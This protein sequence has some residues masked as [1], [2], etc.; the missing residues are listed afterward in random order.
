VIEQLML[1]SKPVAEAACAALGIPLDEVSPRTQFTVNR[2]LWK[3]GFEIPRYDDFL[4]RL[5]ERFEGFNDVALRF[6]G[7]RGEDEREACRAAGVNLFVS[8]EE[9]LDGIIAF[10]VLLLSSDNF[11]DTRFEYRLPVARAEVQRQL[12]TSIVS[13]PDECT[14]RNDGENAR[15]TQLAYLAASVKWMKSLPQS[16]RVGLRRPDA[17]MP[18]FADDPD[19]PFRFTHTQFWADADPIE[20]QR[21]V[22]QYER[23]VQLLL[24]ADLAGVRNGLDHSRN[25]RRFPTADSMLGRV[26][27]LR[28]A[29]EQAD[30]LRCFPKPYW[31]AEVKRTTFGSSELVYR[32]YRGRP[33]TIFGPRMIS[34][35]PEIDSSRPVVF[36]SVNLLGVADSLPMFWS[37]GESEYSQYWSGYPRRRKLPPEGESGVAGI[38]PAEFDQNVSNREPRIDAPA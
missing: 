17:D 12:G 38:A 6:D 15:G 27:R 7:T 10:N 11:V 30:S 23:I 24:Q 4:S 21:H 13:G 33:F 1:S 5:R 35:L 36:A 20:L 18:H 34:G 25:A 2:I 22:A 37:I 26:S 32:D 28:E 9:F 29:V 16:D 19:R 14:W 8:V 31:L 3:A